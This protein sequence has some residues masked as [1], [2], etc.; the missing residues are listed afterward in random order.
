MVLSFSFRHWRKHMFLPSRG[1][2]IICFHT[3]PAFQMSKYLANIGCG[4]MQ[5]INWQQAVLYKYLALLC[6]YLALP[7]K[8]FAN[9]VQSDEPMQAGGAM[10]MQG[11]LRVATER[12]AWVATVSGSL[13]R[14]L[15]SKRL[16]W[17]SLRLGNQ[18]LILQCLATLVALHFSPATQSVSEWY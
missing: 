3:A 4:S 5:D 12:E 2:P 18:V 7:C 10:L 15:L 1:G 17:D 9:Q 14:K 8:Y 13:K 6:K 11:L 16:P